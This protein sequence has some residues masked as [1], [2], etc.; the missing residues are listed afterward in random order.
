LQLQH[1]SPLNLHCCRISTRFPRLRK[2]PRLLR[3]MRQA[4]RC[5]IRGRGT[6]WCLQTTRALA[7]HPSAARREFIPQGTPGHRRQIH[8]ESKSCCANCAAGQNV[9]RISFAPLR[10]QNEA[11]RWPSSR[12]A[13]TEK[14]LRVRVDRADLGTIR[15]FTSLLC[16]K[17]LRRL[18]PKKRTCG[19]TEAKL[20]ADCSRH[21]PPCYSSGSYG[22]EIETKTIEEVLSGKI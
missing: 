4:R 13:W 1:L 14:S 18:Q 12:T 2:T 17:R 19:A 6:G 21:F 16:R 22:H 9:P 15:C 3:K 5:T 11:E 8:K 10:W 7:F 20:S